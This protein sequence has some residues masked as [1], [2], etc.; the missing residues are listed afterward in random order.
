MHMD[1][2]RF[3]LTVLLACLGLYGSN[4]AAAELYDVEIIVFSHAVDTDQGESWDTREDDAGQARSAAGNRFTELSSGQFRLKPVSYSLQQGGSY[5]V[6][7][8]RA[9]RQSASAAGAYPVRASTGDGHSI[10]GSVRL[11]RGRYLHLDVDLLLRNVVGP[12][13]ASVHRLAEKRRMRSD[14]LHYFDHPRFGLLAQVTPY[15][16]AAAPV[17]GTPSDSPAGATGGASTP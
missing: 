7:L 10:E 17:G 9:W 14:E 13:Y 5:Q 8:H 12:G 3:T 4:A 6:L 15:R 2:R 16:A 11:T 1:I